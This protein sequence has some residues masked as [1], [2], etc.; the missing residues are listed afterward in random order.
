MDESRRKILS[1]AYLRTL[2]PT[3]RQEDIGKLAGIENQ[4]DVS[5]FLKTARENGWLQYQMHWPTMEEMYDV[6]KDVESRRF[7]PFPE[8]ERKVKALA[9]SRKGI[10]PKLVMIF[11]GGGGGTDEAR[12]AEFGRQ[13]GLYI[14]PFV[15]DS[16]TCAVAWGR[17]IEAWIKNIGGVQSGFNC[18]FF[19]MSGEPLNNRNDGLSSSAAARLLSECY[20]PDDG[21][22]NAKEGRYFTLEGV[23]ARIPRDLEEQ[24]NTIKRF[25]DKCDSYRK[26]F[27]DGKSKGLVED[28]DMIVSG[29]GDIRTSSNDPLYQELVKMEGDS[30]G[31]FGKSIADFSDGNLGGIWLAKDP[32]NRTHVSKVDEINRRWLGVQKSHIEACAARADI[33]SKPGVFVLAFDK[34]KVNILVQ[35]IGL[36]NHIIVSQS[37]AQALLKALPEVP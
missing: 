8:L 25:V 29:L 28:V 20:V 34:N 18:C 27:G 7:P 23:P 22:T 19:P 13:A 36:V 32:K 26:I 35:V 4:S 3:A 12:K 15:K 17:T 33:G 37:L 10:V 11:E 5:K 1:V 2:D 30:S 24:A 31:K 9:R 6:I 16:R 21:G 14:R